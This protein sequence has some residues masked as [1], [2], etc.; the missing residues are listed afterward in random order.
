MQPA[1]PGT[2]KNVVLVTGANGGTGRRVVR[3]LLREGGYTVRAL[4]RSRERL[5]AAMMKMGLDL[6]QEEKEGKIQVFV[7]DLYNVRDEMFEDLVAVVSCT[8]VNVG[9]RD[10]PDRGKYFQGVKFYAPEIL[11]DSPRNVEYVGVARLMEGVKKWWD[12]FELGGVDVI[13]FD[14]VEE[15]RRVWGAL[16]DVVMGGVSDSFARASASGELVFGGQVRTENSGGFCSI[17]TVNFERALDLSEFTGLRLRVRGDGK[18]Y[19]LIVRCEDRWDGVAQC[20][21]FSTNKEGWTVVEAP[22]DEFRAVF[23]A[24]TVEGKK[25]DAGNV[26]AFQL[27]LS[28]F[29]YDGDLNPE[30]EAGKFELR[31]ASMTAYKKGEEVVVPRVVFVGSAGVT[32]VLR[33]EE[34]D[35]EKQPPAVRMNDMLGRILEWK[36]AGEDVVRRSGVP[37]TIVRPC[38]LTEKE[39]VGVEKLKLEQGDRMTGQ[40]SREDV[41][42]LLVKA[43]KNK[44]LVN[45][46][47]EL[48]S[49]GEGVM[50]KGKM[51]ERLQKLKVDNEEKERGYAS[52]PFVPAEE[53]VKS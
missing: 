11:D 40:V 39:A 25:L 42:P 52:F 5:E 19:K 7:S 35:L 47:V 4:T 43:L 53:A 6:G 21:S 26:V 3:D 38:A 22:F 45:K 16:D 9:P 12:T 8:G 1:S 33:L 49:V 15:V 41:A 10:D 17:R 18:R 28:K 13:K 31:V 37:Y 14:D 34:F 24:K 51:E 36:L 48:A 2:R 50:V 27:M 32:R 20:F 44:S 23:R 29:E 46:T 30:F